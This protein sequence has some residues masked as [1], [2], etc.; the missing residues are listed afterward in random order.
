LLAAANR[1]AVTEPAVRK[2]DEEAQGG[3][4][5]AAGRVLIRLVIEELEKPAPE[6]EP[7]AKP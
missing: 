3:G 5:G 7:E 6:P 2:R 4:R 1:E